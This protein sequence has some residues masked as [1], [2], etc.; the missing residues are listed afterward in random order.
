MISILLLLSLIL[1]TQL[2]TVSFNIVIM[3]FM[4]LIIMYKFERL[5]T[6]TKTLYT[7]SFII[8]IVSAFIYDSGYVDFIVKG[9]LSISIYFIIMFAGV[10]PKRL[11]ITQLMIK[12]RGLL[13]IIGFILVTPH[14]LLHLFE[15]LNGI[16]LFG[17]AAYALMVPLTLISFQVVRREIKPKDWN[18]ILKASYVIYTLLFLH[19]LWVAPYEDKLLYIVILTLY[20]NNKLLLE[21]KK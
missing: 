9:Y 14:A 13:S 15:F 8:A 6:Y 4:M 19:V 17:I 20:I 3:S 21:F 2:L 7:L 16:N 10:F 1:I 5:F 12:Y 11:K 18:N